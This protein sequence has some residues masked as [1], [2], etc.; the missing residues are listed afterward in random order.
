MVLYPG[1]CTERR[2]NR[3]YL[4]VQNIIPDSLSRAEYPDDPGEPTDAEKELGEDEI[5]Y[6]SITAERECLNDQE[7][8]TL[9]DCLDANVEDCAESFVAD[10]FLFK[11]C[12]R[13]TYDF[14]DKIRQTNCDLCGNKLNEEHNH[15]VTDDVDGVT[16]ATTPGL[17]ESNSQIDQVSI[18]DLVTETT[19]VCITYK[20]PSGFG[21]LRDLVINGSR[22]DRVVKSNQKTSYW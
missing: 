5:L 6:A 16:E 17:S 2:G 3:S 19:E 12:L 15:S 22:N 4:R 13:F 20:T 11:D 8:E 14:G 21:P 18:K 1:R 10:W 7:S 9:S